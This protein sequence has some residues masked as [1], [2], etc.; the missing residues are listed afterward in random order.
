MKNLKF[1][2]LIIPFLFYSCSSKIYPEDYEPIRVFLKTQKDISKDKKY[3]LQSN[4]EHNK[5]TLR[6]FNRGEGIEHIVDPNDPIDY[7]DG[8]YVEKHWRK[9]YQKY[10]QDTIKKYWKKEDF[11]DF[12]FVLE[13]G[14]ASELSELVLSK[15]R[16]IIIDGVILLSEPLYY[17]NKKYVIFFFDK[18]YFGGS[19]TS[20]VIVMK[21]EKGKWIIVRVMGDYIYS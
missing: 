5:Q 9:M 4:K 6:L 17:M 14:T 2:L 15:Y 10:A 1:I 13:K 19:S 11:P 12:N 3:I 7:T 16:G 8:L 20:R 21:K 18:V